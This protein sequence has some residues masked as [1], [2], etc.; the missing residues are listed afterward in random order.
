MFQYI[1]TN[2]RT[3][4]NKYLASKDKIQKIN[5]FKDKIS[6][7][8]KYYE[9][10]LSNQVIDYVYKQDNCLKLLSVRY[11]KERF[12]HLTGIDFSN[13]KADEKIEMLKNG[14]N[15]KPIYIEN[16]TIKKL[17]VLDSLPKV[18]QAD[19]KVLADLREVKQAQRIGVNRAIKTKENDLLLA[20]YDFQP[21]IFEPKSLL[22]I[23]EAK[24]YDNIPENTVL[25]IFKESKDKNAI[26]M[27]PIS[28]NTK[29][30]GSIENSTKML[31]AVG[32]YAK[33]QSNLLEKQQIKKRKI[34]KLRQR[35]MER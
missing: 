34:A 22:N 30:L 32:I 9:E 11:K 27:E 35:G 28:L 12:P 23:K 5:G 31:I 4:K 20:L 24:Q 19:S 33:E 6:K 8:T 21:E 10:N 14:K 1:D 13:S 16:A 18:L 26:H 25:A 2:M 29:A 15:T 17:E 7:V 3:F